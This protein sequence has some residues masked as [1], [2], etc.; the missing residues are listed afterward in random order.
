MH[1]FYYSFDINNLNPSVD[2]KIIELINLLYEDI[3]VEDIYEELILN[4]IKFLEEERKSKILIIKNYSELVFFLNNK[5]SMI[6]DKIEICY[7]YSKNMIKK[8]I[9]IPKY[10]MCCQL[11]I[12]PKIIKETMIYILLLIDKCIVSIYY[13]YY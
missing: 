10:M 9:N 3:K 12:S 4:I 11:S 5:N 13:Y 1:I 7:K 8:L 2:N 6:Y